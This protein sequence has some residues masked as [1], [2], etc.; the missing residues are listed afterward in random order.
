MI[1]VNK[2]DRK[3][4]PLSLIYYAPPTSTTLATLYSSTL[5]RLQTILIVPKTFRTAD[6]EE[7]TTEWLL[8]KLA[9]N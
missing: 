3:D 7:L 8:E 5:S 4:Y 2:G 9:R 6:V 1:E